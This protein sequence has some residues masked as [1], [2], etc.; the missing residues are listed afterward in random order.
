M[1]RAD[2]LAQLR[3]D[4]STKFGLP[5]EG[6][7]ITGLLVLYNNMLQSLFQSQIQTL[8]VVMLGIGLMLFILFRSFVWP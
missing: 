5:D 8:G 4:L 2:L 1:R 7:V 3:R 6:F